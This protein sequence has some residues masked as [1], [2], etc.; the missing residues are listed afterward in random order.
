MAPSAAASWT[1]SLQP[2]ACARVCVRAYVRVCVCMCVS[3]CVCLCWRV[4]V[5][6]YVCICLIVFDRCSVAVCRLVIE[7]RPSAGF[8][9]NSLI[10]EHCSVAPDSVIFCA[11]FVCVGGV[12]VYV[13][14]CVCACVPPVDVSRQ[15]LLSHPKCG[16]GVCVC[17]WVRV[18]ARVSVRA[19]VRVCVCVCVCV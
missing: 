7:N 16:C 13:C 19:C 5:C 12:R 11:I 15:K 14:E 3:V 4:C 2:C 8:F 1:L 6:V 17:V 10:E 9:S 18:G